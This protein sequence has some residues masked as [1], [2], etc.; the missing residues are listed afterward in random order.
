MISSSMHALGQQ[1]GFHNNVPGDSSPKADAEAD[2]VPMF[3]GSRR[4]IPYPEVDG[5]D[6]LTRITCFLCPQNIT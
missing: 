5:D 6:T 3:T 1:V 4:I 2:L